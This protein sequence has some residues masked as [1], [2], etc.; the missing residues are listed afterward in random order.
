MQKRFKT[1]LILTSDQKRIVWHIKTCGPK[2]RSSLAID[3]EMHNAS[4]TRLARELVMLGCIDELDDHII[5]RGRPSVPL[6]ISGRA[7]Y[8][9]G[10]MAHPGWL[11]IVLMDFAGKVLARHSEPFNSPDPR[12]FIELISARLKELSSATEIMRLRFLGLG[13]A[14]AGNV[15]DAGSTSRWTVKWLEGWREVEY[16]HFFEDILGFPVWVENESTLAGLADFYDN[17]LMRHFGSAISVFVG[18]GVGGSIIYRR[19]IISGE[20][21]NAGDI[22]RLFPSL[23]DPRPSGIDLVRDINAAGGELRSL[24][25]VGSCL[26]THAEVINAWVERASNQLLTL[27]ASGAA[28]VDPGAIIVTGSIPRPV[29]NAVGEKMRAAPWIFGSAPK[30]TPSIYVTKLGSWAIPMGAAMLPIHDIISIQAR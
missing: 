1:D 30:P 15:A 19:D 28:W 6:T 21:G 25:D 12:I 5:G 7:G 3:L 24:F 27:A 13:I 9:A 22:G 10:V 2:P 8:S 18:H 11:E 26:E 20:Y 4:M 16:P 14:I 17:G 23:D 29:L